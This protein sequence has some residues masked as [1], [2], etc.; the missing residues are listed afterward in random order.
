MSSIKVV[1]NNVAVATIKYTTDA[2]LAAELRAILTS[3]GTCEVAIVADLDRKTGPGIEAVIKDTIVGV[4][5]EQGVSQKSAEAQPTKEEAVEA[6]CDC[7]KCEAKAKAKADQCQ[8][9][10]CV[11]KDALT[12]A[13]YNSLSEDA[14]AELIWERLKAGTE[15]HAEAMMA[16]AV[17]NVI[18]KAKTH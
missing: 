13:A 8:C 12:Y 11:I 10:T 15:A 18:A 9:P 5:R 16:Q 17:A 14:T 6:P 7:P 2:A 1:A 3:L 4:L